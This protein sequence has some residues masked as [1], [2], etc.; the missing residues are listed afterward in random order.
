[1]PSTP[2]ETI[3]SDGIEYVIGSL[4]V[5]SSEPSTGPW[6]Y[7]IGY[8]T[9]HESNNNNETAEIFP[10]DDSNS[11]DDD[12]GDSNRENESYDWPMP[13]QQYGAIICALEIPRPTE[14]IEC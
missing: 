8:L 10:D 13:A 2:E 14:Y 6:S 12:D 4:S 7:T 3:G 1:M 5:S 11:D 9:D